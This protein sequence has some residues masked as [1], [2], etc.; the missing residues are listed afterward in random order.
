[1]PNPLAS[2]SAR[3]FLWLDASKDE[4]DTSRQSE[5]PEALRRM[6]DNKLRVYV[7]VLRRMK[8]GREPAES[9]VAIFARVQEL[10]E[11]AAEQK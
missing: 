9:D 11:G 10:R 5:G 6:T 8:G 4:N 3:V 1:M 2:F 7:D